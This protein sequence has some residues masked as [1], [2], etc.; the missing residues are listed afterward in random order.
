MKNTDPR[1]P[2]RKVVKVENEMPDSTTITAK[3]IYFECGHIGKFNPIF[4]YSKT[5]HA[6]CFKCRIK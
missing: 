2:L 4:D 6:H 1:G 5:E 3:L